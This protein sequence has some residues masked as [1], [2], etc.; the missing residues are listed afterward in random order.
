[1]SRAARPLHVV[2]RLPLACAVFAFAAAGTH[3]LFPDLGRIGEG[4]DTSRRGEVVIWR[5]H[6]NCY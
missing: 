3:A 6:F 5:P 4:R 2:L 1:M